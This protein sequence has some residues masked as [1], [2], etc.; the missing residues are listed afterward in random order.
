M[1][2]F[3]PLTDGDDEQQTLLAGEEEYGQQEPDVTPSLT[4][5]PM[6]GSRSCSGLRTRM[7][8]SQAEDLC[9]CIRREGIRYGI[10]AEVR[11]GERGSSVVVTTWEGTEETHVNEGEWDRYFKD[12]KSIL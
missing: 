9:S 3:L 11:R 7:N 8:Q 12:V 4:S 5:E 2:H 10:V 1:D 6:R